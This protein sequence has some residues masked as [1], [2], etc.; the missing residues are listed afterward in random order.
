MEKPTRYNSRKSK[1]LWCY[2]LV[3]V[4]VLNKSWRTFDEARLSVS[5]NNCWSKKKSEIH[6]HLRYCMLY[7]S[8][9]FKLGTKRKGTRYS[10]Q[11]LFKFI[12]GVWFPENCFFLL[13]ITKIVL[14]FCNLQFL[15]SWVLIL[16]T[17]RN[18]FFLFHMST[19]AQDWRCVTHETSFLTQ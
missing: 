3:L 13:K 12:I 16:A 9:V 19:F 5:C 10:V 2:S 7:V 14:N 15:Q 4:A 6:D 1:L 18:F 17:V 11:I 8:Y